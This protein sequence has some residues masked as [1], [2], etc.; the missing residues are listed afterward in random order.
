M[1]G[2]ALWAGASDDF[3]TFVDEMQ[4]KAQ[5][6]GP[7]VCA[8]ALNSGEE[9]KLMRLWAEELEQGSSAPSGQVLGKLKTIREVYQAHK[10]AAEAFRD[11]YTGPK[12]VKSHI[13]DEK[14]AIDE[15]QFFAGMS[16]WMNDL[17][18][19]YED[20]T[21]HGN[22]WTARGELQDIWDYYVKE[23]PVNVAPS[24]MREDGYYENWSDD[25]GDDFGQ[26]KSVFESST[27]N[28]GGGDGGGNAG[29]GSGSS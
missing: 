21:A 6:R 28:A 3:D 19:A 27:M 22:H 9:A 16:A 11:T 17:V 25:P 1:M 10:V 26:A 20:W 4:T 2:A 23:V 15:A 12:G 18:K 13:R 5:G 24:H 8:F 29:G 14:H 7:D